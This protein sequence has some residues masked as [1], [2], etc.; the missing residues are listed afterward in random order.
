MLAKYVYDQV[1]NYIKVVPGNYFEIGIWDGTGI[2]KLSKI[3]PEK[4]FFAVDPFIE[5]GH[6]RQLSLQNKGDSLVS[7]K[8][9][10]LSNL[11]DCSNISL[12]IVTSLEF[13]KSL[14]PSQIQDM[15]VSIV[16][17]DGDHNYENVVVDYNLAMRLLGPKAGVVI[18][19][20]LHVPDVKRAVEEFETIYHSRIIDKLQLDNSV[21]VVYNINEIVV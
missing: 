1:I 6:T 19:D 12:S 18:F 16:F 14:S 7:I 9:K 11:Q 13:E 5:D 20:D 15:D 8:E 10:A 21:H 4:K 2:A 17:I 3:F